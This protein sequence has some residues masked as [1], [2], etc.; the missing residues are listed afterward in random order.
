MVD[1]NEAVEELSS[2]TLSNP[3][4]RVFSLAKHWFFGI[5]IVETHFSRSLLLFTTGLQGR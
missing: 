5:S 4:S 1:A 2:S 3:R